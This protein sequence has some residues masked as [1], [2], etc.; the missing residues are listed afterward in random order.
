MT[1]YLVRRI[2]ASIP[3][4]LGV[5]TLV[6]L[7]VEAAPGDPFRLEPGAGVDSGA[8]ARLH[9]VFG[10]DRPVWRRYAGWLGDAVRGDLGVSFSL[11]RPVAGLVRD[12][13]GN[14]A[15]LA[16]AAIALQFLAGTA[17]GVAAAAL[18]SR[19]LDRGFSLLAGIVYSL[20]SY[21]LG[22]VLVSLFSVRLGW[23]PV[24]QMHSIEAASMAG[25]SRLA[26][27][28]LHLVLPC[29]A[30][31]LPAAAGVALYVRDEVREVLRRAP[32]EMARARGATR[33]RLLVRHALGGALVPVVTLLGL[34]LPGLVGG[35]AVLEVLFA[36]PGMGRLAYEAVLA[37]D[38]PLALG[39]AWIGS[40]AVVAGSI[41]A[42]LLAAWAD[43]R[44]RE[45]V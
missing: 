37:S 2:L 38:E 36:W 12:A 17:A 15:I 3:L 25:S 23:L 20:P 1:G 28:A 31:T 13:V 35:S 24:S 43:P 30:L 27:A 42:D 5:L 8:A 19:A 44:L 32:I 39:C 14:T 41:A 26:D 18:R 7:L 34:A 40:V 22:L 29:L 16:G 9:E 4:L 6:F 45:G 11:R 21:W 10:A 33:R